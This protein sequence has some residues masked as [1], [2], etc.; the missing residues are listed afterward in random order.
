MMLRGPG[1]EYVQYPRED[2]E[3][4]DRIGQR[5]ERILPLYT[6]SV[7]YRDLYTVHG[8]L[9][10]WFYEDLGVIC[11]TNELWTG[12]KYYFRQQ[13]EQRGAGGGGPF[14]GGGGQADQ[15]LFNDLLMFGQTYVPWKKFKHPVY[16]EVELGGWVQMQGR[17][18]PSFQLEDECHRNFAFTM[19]HA[20][21]MPLVE[22]HN[23]EVTPLGGDL[24]RLRVDL[25]NRRLIPTTTA[26]G[27]RRRVGPR[28][29]VEIAGGGLT[30][31]AGGTIRDRYTSPME[32]VEHKPEQI[33][34]D[35]GLGGE[36][37][38]TFQWIVSGTG[39]A[40]VRVVGPRVR[41]VELKVPVR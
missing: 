20:E 3:V 4:Y 41:D 5:G 30:V 29:C 11:F 36:S 33:W 26:Q 19:Y 21:Q 12:R 35:G 6:Y 8:G 39:E 24:R 27:A 28:D 1:A 32:F 15:M 9:I 31:V 34:L 10:N 37:T 17:V 13:E 16:G 25:S 2:V 22:V 40:T 7:I 18:P 38:M 14:G 23:A